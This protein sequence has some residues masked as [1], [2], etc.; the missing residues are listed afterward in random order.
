MASS[1]CRDER[2][3]RETHTRFIRHDNRCSY[4]DGS[5]FYFLLMVI[6]YGRKSQCGLCSKPLNIRSTIT[7]R[8]GN[9]AVEYSRRKKSNGIK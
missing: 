6:R 4:F 2:S 5:H 3:K 8:L 1:P 9:G 7:S